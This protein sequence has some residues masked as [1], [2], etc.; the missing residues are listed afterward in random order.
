MLSPQ[1]ERQLKMLLEL[2]RRDSYY[3]QMNYRQRMDVSNRL[4]DE[5]GRFL[6]NVYNPMDEYRFGKKEELRLDLDDLTYN[7]EPPREI[8]LTKVEGS[9]GTYRI[10]EKEI[11]LMDVITFIGF[12]GALITAFIT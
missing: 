4:R 8:K 10:D 2:M 6:P 12:M 5:M 11:K 3:H 1:E 9:Y 7:D